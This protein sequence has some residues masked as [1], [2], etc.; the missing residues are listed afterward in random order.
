VVREH[1]IYRSL[2]DVGRSPW[3]GISRGVVGVI[4]GVLVMCWMVCVVLIC[5]VMK[6]AT[7]S[8]WWETM[9]VDLAD[10]DVADEPAGSPAP[11]EHS[12]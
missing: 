12:V 1:A 11:H 8:P 7:R 5:A 10:L 9:L 2:G 3:R 4:A 6:H